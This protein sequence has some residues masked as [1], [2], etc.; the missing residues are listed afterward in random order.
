MHPLAKAHAAVRRPQFRS[1]LSILFGLALA[2]CGGTVGPN[3][4]PNPPPPSAV[5]APAPVEPQRT[6]VGLVVPLSGQAAEVGMALQDAAELAL[7]DL[8]APDIELLPAD[9]GSSAATATGAVQNVITGGADVVIGPL[10]ATSVKAASPA[11]RARGLT[12]LGFSTDRAA[13]GGGVYLMGF[14]PEEQV[15]TVIGYAADSGLKRFAAVI[16]QG[17]YGEVVGAAFEVA[18]GS[19]GGM[20]AGIERYKSGSLQPTESLKALLAP[21]PDGRPQI[22]ALFVPE[23]GSALRQVTGVLAGLGFDPRAVRL[24]G[25]DQWAGSD[26]GSDPL[27]LGGWYAGPSPDRFER[28]ASHFQGTYGH[29]PPRIAAQAYDAMT[30]AVLLSKQAGGFADAARVLTAPD[31]FAGV[32][33]LFRFR[34]DGVPQHGLAILEVAASGPQVIRPAPETFSGQG[35]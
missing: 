5:T 31:G 21:G 7:F 32:D 13:G 14:M 9:A 29:R 4:N 25:T 24:L 3:T 27:T 28:F 34:A 26:L 11:A 23:G 33:G 35:Y 8:N 20:V 12:V 1:S 6:Q 17:A 10:G 22:D 30:L 16:P 18:V 2:A 15:S 19:H